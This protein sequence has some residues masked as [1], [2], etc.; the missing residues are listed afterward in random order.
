MDLKLAQELVR[1]YHNPLVLVLLDLR[2][3]YD[4]VDREC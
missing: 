1:I 2:K 4:P 3:A